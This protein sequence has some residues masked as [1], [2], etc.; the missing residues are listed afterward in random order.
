M[1]LGLERL[2]LQAK[3][4]V[5]NDSSTRSDHGDQRQNIF[6]ARLADVCGKLFSQEG[7]RKPVASLPDLLLLLL[8]TLR[9]SELPLSMQPDKW[10]RSP[11]TVLTPGSRGAPFRGSAARGRCSCSPLAECLHRKWSAL[12]IQLIFFQ[13]LIKSLNQLYFR[14]EAHG[15]LTAHASCFAEPEPSPIR[16]LGSFPHEAIR[17]AVML[18]LPHATVMSLRSTPVSAAA[19]ASAFT[20]QSREQHNEPTLQVSP[21]SSKSRQCQRVSKPSTQDNSL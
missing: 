1:R 16:V 20:C 13:Q 2:S 15:D 14:K 17:P 11:S 8:E 6:A 3:Q 21:N 5:K 9:P 18:H 12:N 4:L 10:A 7:D 19:T